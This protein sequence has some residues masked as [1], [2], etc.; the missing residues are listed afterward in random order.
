MQGVILTEPGVL[1]AAD[2]P[3]PPPPGPGE[4]RLAVHRVGLCGTDLH[5]FHGRQ[6]F[7]SYPRIL[8]HE[9]AVEVFDVGPGVTHV[10]PGDICAVRPYLA[11]GTCDACGRGITNACE[12]L[13][14]LGVHTDGGMRERIVLP[15]AVLH[16]ANGL[17]LDAVMLVETLGIGAHAVR[18]ADPVPGERALVVGG[19]P[20]GLGVATFLRAR[21]VE[22]LL[23]DVVPE[24]RA[25]AEQW[26][27][28]RTIDPGTDAPAAVRA[29]FAGAL[30]TL[31]MDATG[32]SASMHAAFG[33]AGH[34][35]R[36]VFVGL[37]VGDVTFHDPDLHRRELTLLASRNATAADVDTVI[38]HVRAGGVDAT[39][40]IAEH[41]P[42]AGLPEALPRWAGARGAGLKGVVALGGEAGR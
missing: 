1:V 13:A 10:R 20:I 41:V 22:P 26:G 40:W 27:G 21:G 11:C 17:P 34:G 14:T 37:F 25:F 12:R 3:E 38:A 42:L 9:L 31:V 5:A 18:R 16:P 23:A 15:A 24:R 8:G 33:L 4:A 35:G 7:F 28:L 29:A 19:G 6:P 2:L 36:I 30:P 39:P 32:N